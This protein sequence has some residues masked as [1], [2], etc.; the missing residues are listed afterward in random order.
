VLEVEISSFLAGHYWSMAQSE[1]GGLEL[2]E[3][4]NN[5][6]KEGETRSKESSAQ[7]KKIERVS[8]EGKWRQ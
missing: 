6:G 3:M 8:K 7:S 2:V 5:H 4:R 1:A